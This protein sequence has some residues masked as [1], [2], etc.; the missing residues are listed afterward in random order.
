M[1]LVCD[2]CLEN[3]L[4]AHT[5]ENMETLQPLCTQCAPVDARLFWDASEVE[6]Y[7]LAEPDD[8]IDWDEP[9]DWESSDDTASECSSVE[10]EM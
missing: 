10:L 9:D 8:W 7:E 5:V 4:L 3:V 2:L 6:H 1:E